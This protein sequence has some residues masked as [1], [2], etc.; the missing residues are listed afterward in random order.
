MLEKLEYE[1]EFTTPAFIGGANPNGFPEVRPSSIIGV[2][3]YWFRVLVGAFVKDTE[4]LFKLEGEIFG[5]QE[6]AGKVWIRISE[7]KLNLTLSKTLSKQE[8]LKN[9]ERYLFGIKAIKGAVL[10]DRGSK[11]KLLILTPRKLKD[12]VDFLVRFSFTFGNIGYRARKG[13]GSLDFERKIENININ[14]IQDL[15]KE[16]FGNE[17]KF[18]R[19][20]EFPNISNAVFLK[21]KNTGKNELENLGNLYYSFRRNGKNRTV[22][23]ITFVKDFLRKQKIKKPVVKNH[24]FGLPIMYSSKSLSC[25]GKRAQAQLNWKLKKDDK[26]NRRPAPFWISIKRKEAYAVLFT[27]KFLPD[28]AEIILTPKGNY[29]KKCAKTSPPSPIV[30]KDVNFDYSTVEDFLKRAGFTDKIFDGREVF[31]V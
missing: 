23:Y 17:M 28:E 15:L 11:F 16:T 6:K 30:L 20:D 29:W 24:M 19:N 22:E 1:L 5:N 8:V 27:S 25:Q 26:D 18:I 14:S 21:K 9:M 31:N 12:F 7:Q 3:R 13:F 10:I 2:L 4:E